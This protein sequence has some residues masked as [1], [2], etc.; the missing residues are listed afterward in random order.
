MRTLRVIAA[1]TWLPIIVA[2]GTILAGW[3]FWAIVLATVGTT[4][5]S[6]SLV[7]LVGGHLRDWREKKA[8]ASDDG[9]REVVR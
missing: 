6:G 2:A 8:R 1:Y 4:L 5:T 3:G 7:V 9:N